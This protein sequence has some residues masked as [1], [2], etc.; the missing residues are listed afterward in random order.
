[1]SGDEPFYWRMAEHPAGAHNFPYA[2]RIGV[3]WL[4]H[5][6][7]FSHAASFTMLSLL[8][9]AASA[10]A[11]YA[12]MR[13][14]GSGAVLAGWLALAYA[15]SPTLF[16][17][18]VRH[19]RSIDPASML[20]MALGCLFIVQRRRAALAVTLLAG[21]TIR[22]STLFLIPFAYAVWAARPVDR[23]ALLD[24]AA[25]SLVPIALYVVLRTSIATAGMQYIPGYR[26]PLLDARLDLLGQALRA[27][28]WE[29][30]LR[31]LAYT[32]GPLWIVAPLALAG[33]RFARAGLILGALCAISMT[34]AF[35]WGRVAFLAAPVVYAA[36]AW[37]LRGHRRLAVALVI[38]LLAVDAGYGVYLQVAGTRHLDNNVG[39]GIP[40][41]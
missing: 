4:V 12:L 34:F 18:L 2:Y 10:G 37:V 13:S 23:R 35:D 38:T 11:L 21:V 25:V 6:L 14:V 30:E 36:G 33:P 27:G 32:Y 5:A 31:R 26:G 15:L 41:Y 39:H 40:V 29:L 7:P 1:M 24:L 17:V 20:V 8:A 22:E 19:G 28:T 3:P 16:A 9:I